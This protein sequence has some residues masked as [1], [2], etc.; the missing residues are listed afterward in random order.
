MA[1]REGASEGL[2]WAPGGSKHYRT[3]WSLY[4]ASDHLLARVEWDGYGHA[5]GSCCVNLTGQGCRLMS[6]KAWDRL[7]C[8]LSRRE[9]WRVN[10]LDLAW[11]DYEGKIVSDPDSAIAAWDGGKFRH[12]KGRPPEMEPVGDWF[13]RIASRTINVGKRKSG[14]VLRCYTKGLQIGGSPG[15][16]R[17]EVEWRSKR[18]KIE[19]FRLSPSCWAATFSG[20]YPWC[21]ELLEASALMRDVQPLPIRSKA[22][23]P[24]GEIDPLVRLVEAVASSFGP[25]LSY[26]NQRMPGVDLLKLIA[27]GRDTASLR[28]L[29]ASEPAAHLADSVD[30]IHERRL[31]GFGLGYRRAS[32]VR[33]PTPTLRPMDGGG[34]ADAD[35][36]SAPRRAAP[37]H[38]AARHGA[39]R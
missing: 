2:R 33:M 27:V 30:L 32:F 36:R 39:S 9:R 6:H 25:Q 13:H 24:R 29:Y 20:A 3:A 26:W 15:W 35:A 34:D 37:H 7:S 22:R 14:K 4:D 16:M 28:R 23:I 19:A 21:A 17:V 10:R 12:G 5:A 1:L 38:R 18:G 8:Y 11:N 31:H